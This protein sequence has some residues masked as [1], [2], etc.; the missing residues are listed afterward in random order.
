MAAA[1]LADWFDINNVFIRY[2]TSLDHGDVE[3][4]VDCFA[5]NASVVSPVLGEFFGHSG[6][7]DRVRA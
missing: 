4:V 5:E 3:S 2:A 7:R 1:S 6:V